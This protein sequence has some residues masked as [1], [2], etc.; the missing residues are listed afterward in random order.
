MKFT[1]IVTEGGLIPADILAE[2]AEATCDGQQAA[3][4]VPNTNQTVYEMAADA[5]QIA[6]VHWTAFQRQLA[7]DSSEQ[8]NTT[9]TRKH[10]IQPLLNQL[11]YDL[12]F[13]G[14]Q[15]ISFRADGHEDAPPVHIVG[16]KN[17]LDKRTSSSR[18]SPHA[19][20]QE[21]LN[22]T[23]HLWGIVSNGAQLRLLRDSSR[24]A[25]PSYLEFDLQAIFDD[26]KFSEFVVLFRLLHRSRLPNTSEN[27]ADCWLEKY[28]QA[29]ISSGGR[30]REKL[31]DGVETAL[32]QLGLGILSHPANHALRTKLAN[33][34]STGTD[35]A[36][37]LTALGFYRQLLRL[38]YRLLFLMVA[39][40]RGLI[41]AQAQDDESTAAPPNQRLQIYYQ[42]YSL[43]RLRKLA[44]Q[45]RLSYSVHDDLWQSLQVTF[46]LLEGSDEQSPRSL[47]LAPLDGD[48]FGESAIRDLGQQ[49]LQ[50]K[51]L[52]NAIRA[53]SLYDDAGNQRRVN[54]AALDVEELGSVYESLL[55]FRPVVELDPIN[56]ELKFGKE[57]KT[58]GSYYTRP[59]LVQEL[60]KS[61]L[62]PVIAERIKPK[63]RKLSKLEAEKALLEIKVCDPT[64]GSGHF[65]LA[66]ARRLGRELASIRANDGDQLTPS[67]FREAVRDVIQHCIFGVDL[68]PLAVDLCKLALW[69]EGHN[70]GKPLSFLDHHIR[71]GNGLI[72]TSKA[73]VEQGIPDNAFTALTGDDKKLAS[74][75]KK[76][77]KGERE[78]FA[79]G[80]HQLSLFGTLSAN[81][82]SWADQVQALDQQA[83][84]S[85]EAVRKKASAYQQ[86]RG[87]AHREFFRYDLWTAAFFQQFEP[88]KQD[89]L[90]STQ[91]LADYD[92]NPNN[93]R[94]DLQGHVIA[95]AAQANFFHWELEF[96]QVFARTQA[97]FDV[98]LGNPPWE[99]LQFIE[100]EH[101]VDVEEIRSTTNAGDRERKIK[102]WRNGTAQQK[103]RIAIFDKAKLTVDTQSRFINASGRFP[104][105]A[106]GRLNTYALFTEQ[107]RNMINAQ[108]RVGLIIPTSIATDDS[109]KD[110]FADLNKKQ[111]LVSLYDFEN[112]KPIFPNVHRSYKFCA[113]TLAG[114]AKISEFVF[115]AQD[116]SDI[117]NV[118]RR[119]S[120]SSEDIALINPNTRTAPVFRTKMDADLVK[121]IYQKIPILIDFN[122]GKNPW[123]MQTR[124]ILNM[125]QA[126]VF[127]LCKKYSFHDALPIYE[128]KMFHSYNHRWS[129]YENGKINSDII[130]N[131]NLSDIITPQY[132]VSKE[133]LSKFFPSEWK[134]DWIVAYRDIARATDE[135][136]CIAAILPF[137]ATDFTIRIA[138]PNQ[139]VLLINAF[140]SV[141]NSIA[142]DYVCRQSLAGTHL[143]DYIFNQLPVLPPERFGEAEL[144][145]IVP[146]VL[147]L[148]Y[149]ANDLQPFAQDVWDEADVPL[150]SLIIQQRQANHA[151]TQQ[152]VDAEIAQQVADLSLFQD[153]APPAFIW[154]EQRR[155]VL[156]AELDALIAKLYG[157]SYDQLRYILDPQDVYGPD[158]PSETF[159]VLKE[160][161]LRQYDEYRTRRLVLEAW[162]A[163]EN[164]AW[165]L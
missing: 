49:R 146:R 122:K 81:E 104:L 153:Q 94:G 4:F 137:S 64:C 43:E 164:K 159:R 25:R 115:F 50:N 140:L 9:I 93:L 67:A 19:V 143:S 37:A 119:F 6:R 61:A 83:S 120:L 44:E 160:R 91:T 101:F 135:R 99:I 138:L 121:T 3:H 114:N 60:I 89:V 130:D 118:Y 155:A 132:W 18:I 82:S 85:V 36:Q 97:G 98:I 63:G 42:H 5:W 30:V 68:N 39:E 84:N 92:K 86:A 20:V 117:N 10:W 136:S 133:N 151:L 96:P 124:R 148:V 46:R 154:D 141:L 26:E 11:G 110:F 139:P 56:F 74:S 52:I 123:I 29:G 17:P 161:E 28:H 112:S 40:E 54:Y 48:L 108:G 90:I 12:S 147:E 66:A 165:A 76:R 107:A 53:L 131:K 77:N 116:Y 45:L 134:K 1:S 69:L 105:T 75:L 22:K 157:L 103:Q 126:E 73:L 34:L 2:V 106:V 129:S 95:L 152:Y 21:Y 100:K 111:Q 47:G 38:V 71:Q 51:Y 109:S 59:E 57:R 150:R 125:G 8:Q 79:A 27:A 58:T 88:S 35:T 55:D 16:S 149:T 23:E 144:R 87:A 24:F 142:F 162:E 31:R 65:L 13:N 163:L 7:L 33:G 128:A 80:G 78:L 14:G 158:F 15:A 72:G 113:I 41:A 70:A 127:N 102:E 32:R 62:E 145:F 156:R